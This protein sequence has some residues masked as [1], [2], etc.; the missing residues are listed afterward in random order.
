[1]HLGAA[2][3]LPVFALFGASN[4]MVW[5]PLVDRHHIFYKSLPCSPCTSPLKG[6]REGD[7]EC[8]KMISAEEVIKVIEESNV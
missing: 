1:M 4:P 2:V 7:A 8:K 3:G 5:R 6:C